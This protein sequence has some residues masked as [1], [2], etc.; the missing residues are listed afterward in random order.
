M[1]ILTARI[2]SFEVERKELLKQ[3]DGILGNG[4]MT[5]RKYGREFEQRFFEYI[6]TR[7]AVAEDLCPRQICLPASAG[8]AEGQAAHVVQSPKEILT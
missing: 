5:L 4:R 3:I 8:M 6:G 2:Y 1:N 7:Y